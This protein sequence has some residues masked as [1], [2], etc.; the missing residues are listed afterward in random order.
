SWDVTEEPSSG[1]RF[2]LK[3]EVARLEKGHLLH[4]LHRAKWNYTAAGE[5]LGIHESTVRKKIR[6]YSLLQYRPH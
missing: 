5:L 3:D 1:D 6:E 2:S 4:A